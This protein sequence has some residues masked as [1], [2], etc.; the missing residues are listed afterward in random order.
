V[1][2]RPQSKQPDQ[3]WLGA[4]RWCHRNLQLPV[5]EASEQRLRKTAMR[6]AGRSVAP[7]H[8]RI[9]PASF[10]KWLAQLL[11][12]APFASTDL[13]AAPEHLSLAA[14]VTPHRLR[15]RMPMPFQRDRWLGWPFRDGS[16]SLTYR[17]GSTV[18]HPGSAAADVR[19]GDRRRQSWK[20]R[21]QPVAGRCIREWRR[22]PCSIRPSHFSNQQP[23]PPALDEHA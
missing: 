19:R 17:P 13:S 8:L 12:S 7:L 22:A 10:S 5:G 20:H 9:Q 11:I 1:L 3:R 15:M 4:W 21:A 18:A 23:S 2:E 16:R 14:A 6:A